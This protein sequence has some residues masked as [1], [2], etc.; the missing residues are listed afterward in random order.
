MKKVG[1]NG[2]ELYSTLDKLHKAVYDVIS[3]VAN[4]DDKKETE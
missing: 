4:K 1:V 3:K 2:A